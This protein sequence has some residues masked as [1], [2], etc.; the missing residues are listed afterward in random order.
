MCHPAKLTQ[1]LLLVLIVALVVCSPAATPAPPTATAIPPTPIPAISTVAPAK[2]PLDL[3]LAADK[4]VFHEPNWPDDI[5]YKVPEMDKV[6][7]G[8]VKYDGQLPMDIYYPPGFDFK[9]KLPAVIVPSTFT[10]AGYLNLGANISWGQVLG[11]SGIAQVTYDTRTPEKDI[12]QVFKY[13]RDNGDEL[14]I[15]TDHLCIWS[16]SADGQLGA[17][18]AMDNDRYVGAPLRCAVFYYGVIDLVAASDWKSKPTLLV[19]KAGL[20][21]WS[22]KDGL[23]HLVDAARAA[24]VPVEYIEYA[25][26]KHGFDLIQD[27]DE[28]RK[29]AAR[30]IEFLK[31]NLLKK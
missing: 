24:N 31:E 29:I 7:V 30:T 8:R 4:Q 27:T 15:D 25:D 19:V 18:V 3:T 17:K 11:A 21:Q 6:M 26:G 12:V 16:F 20:D 9:S 23:D 10:D 13:L 2:P 28:S 1:L 5:V 14:G 22:N